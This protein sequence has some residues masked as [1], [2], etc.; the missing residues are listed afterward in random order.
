MAGILTHQAI[1]IQSKARYIISGHLEMMAAITCDHTLQRA[2]IPVDK[3]TVTID[4]TETLAM[5]EG[6]IRKIEKP[7]PLL[8]VIGKYIQAETK[9]MFVG[10]RPDTSGVRG[11]KWPKLAKSTIQKKISNKVSGLGNQVGA[12]RRPLVASG[13]MKADL[14]NPRSIE[15]NKNGLRYGTDMVNVYGFPY[16]SVHQ[17]VTD[18]IPQRRF[19]FVNE[20][21]LNQICNTVKQW[22]EG[23]KSTFTEMKKSTKSIYK[24]KGKGF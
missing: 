24:G 3:A 14:L 8:K 12:A 10:K 1:K 5:I 2:G 23:D 18:L 20:T 21:D 4:N 19:L 7:E 6:L 9:K 15:I 11:V 16:P 17:T 22:L 13:L